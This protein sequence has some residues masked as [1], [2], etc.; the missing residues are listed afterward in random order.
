MDKRTGF[1]V[2]RDKSGWWRMKSSVIGQARP[3]CGGT[4]GKK[5]IGSADSVADPPIVSTLHELHLTVMCV[6]NL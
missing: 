2:L 5:V 3:I 6:R 1:G 4:G